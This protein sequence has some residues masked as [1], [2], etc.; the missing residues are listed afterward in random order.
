[1]VHFFVVRAKA[2]KPPPSARHPDRTVPTLQV[3]LLAAHLVVATSLLEYR[4]SQSA[5]S[6]KVKGLV[7]P[8]GLGTGSRDSA[9]SA[10][11]RSRTLPVELSKQAG[12]AALDPPSQGTGVS[13]PV[14]GPAAPCRRLW[15][16]W[17]RAYVVAAGV[18]WV[19]AELVHPWALGQGTLPF[20]PLMGVSVCGAVGVVASWGLL[21]VAAASPA[22]F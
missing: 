22:V 14:E 18:V 11:R 21:L 17:D 9:R 12:D 2:S 3:M 13:T 20:L 8:H 15:T 10:E 19:L 6:L 7:S 1:M 5:P 4:H 16:V